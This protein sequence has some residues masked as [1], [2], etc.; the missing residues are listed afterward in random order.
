MELN[1]EL[2][3]YSGCKDPTILEHKRF[4]GY[5]RTKTGDKQYDT[6][7]LDICEGLETQYNYRGLFHKQNRT[8]QQ[9]QQ[10]HPNRNGTT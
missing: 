3:G 9:Q 1:S 5:K 8:K 10:Q 4:S 6:N 7:E 2:S